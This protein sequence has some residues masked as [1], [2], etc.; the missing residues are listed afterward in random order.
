[1]KKIFIVSLIAVLFAAPAF[2]AGTTFAVGTQIASGGENISV[3]SNN[4]TAAI[5]SNN[6]AFAATTLHTSGSKMFGTSSVSTK[7]YSTPA[8]ALVA[9]TASDSSDFDSD[10]KAL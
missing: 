6:T 8:T 1:M 5:Y 9:P 7:I 10:W 4:V 3:L 2:A